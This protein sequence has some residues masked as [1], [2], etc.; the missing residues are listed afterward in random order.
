LLANPSSPIIVAAANLDLADTVTGLG[1]T[2]SG[3][4]PIE[5]ARLLLGA[6]RIVGI[7]GK[8]VERRMAAMSIGLPPV[9]QCVVS[10]RP[11]NFGF[12]M[13]WATSGEL[14]EA[15]RGFPPACV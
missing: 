1:S 8:W 2:V 4:Q 7:D 6:C 12:L 15:M 5:A 14:A 11:V 10:H 3:V 9:A 13:E